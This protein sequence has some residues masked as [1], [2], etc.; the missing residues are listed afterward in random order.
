MPTNLGGPGGFQ[1]LQST[2]F[3][4]SGSHALITVTLTDQEPMLCTVCVT[5]AHTHCTE[6]MNV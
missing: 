2:T 1:K 3:T 4:L 5:A 6:Q